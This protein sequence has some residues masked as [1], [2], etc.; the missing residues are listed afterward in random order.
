MLRP[1]VLAAI[2]LGAGPA[3]GFAEATMNVKVHE[4]VGAVKAVR[5]DI[6]DAEAQAID[7]AVR[8]TT[9]GAMLDRSVTPSELRGELYMI[10]EMRP[11]ARP[12]G[13]ERRAA[14]SF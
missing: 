8:H 4:F 3:L 2:E 6:G 14:P 5:P 1:A 9:L 13:D 11:P 10:V 7:R 12:R